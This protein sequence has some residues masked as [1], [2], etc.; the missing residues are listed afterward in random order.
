MRDSKYNLQLSR[1]GPKKCIFSKIVADV[2]TLGNFPTSDRKMI[3]LVSSLQ[4]VVFVR[5]HNLCPIVRMVQNALPGAKFK[6]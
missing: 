3:F 4:M 1:N 2:S 6:K 5:Q